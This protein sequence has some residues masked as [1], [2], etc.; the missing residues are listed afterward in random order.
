MNQLAFLL[1]CLVL[2]SF[3]GAADL[4]PC[5][6][7]NKPSIEVVARLMTPELDTL[8]PREQLTLAAQS[9]RPGEAD[10]ITSFQ[11]GQE[12]N[13]VANLA[14][15]GCPV[16][17]IQ[18]VI[19]HS[20]LVV[21]IAKEVPISSCRFR[22]VYDHELKHVLLAQQSL[23]R[24]VKPLRKRLAAAVADLGPDDTRDAGAL[25]TAL[26]A[27]LRT[28]IVDLYADFAEENASLDT[29][30]EGQRLAVLCQDP[31]IF[32]AARGLTIEGHRRTAKTTSVQ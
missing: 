22:A 20:R 11:V 1:L 23:D 16:R 9:S 25:R 10:G 7:P 8:T 3:A 18:A 30:E 14:A 32:D 5:G 12:L 13:L 26:D 27:V 24:S 15:G 6:G 28:A 2:P 17:S 4:H 19:R 31:T 29:P 21:Y